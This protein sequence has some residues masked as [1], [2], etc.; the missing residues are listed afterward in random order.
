MAFICSV[1]RPTYRE[2][3]AGCHADRETG[4]TVAGFLPLMGRPLA[5][6]KGKTRRALQQVSPAFLRAGRVIPICRRPLFIATPGVADGQGCPSFGTVRWSV[7]ATF[8]TKAAASP[9]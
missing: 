3:F 4:L 8:E 7:G 2:E 5:P 6:D 1:E 9:W